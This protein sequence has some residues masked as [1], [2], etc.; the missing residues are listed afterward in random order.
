MKINTLLI[1]KKLSFLF[2]MFLLIAS[3]ETK[4]EV[5]SENVST[6]AETVEEDPLPSWNE[7]SSK[8]AIMAYVKDISDENSSNFIPVTDRIATF[9]NDGTLWSEQPIY[10]QFFF[11]LDRIKKMAENHPEWK[12]KQPYKAVLEN[13]MPTLMKQGKNGLVEIIMTTHAGMTTDEFE[14][15]VNDW[16]STAKHPEKDKLFTE[17]IY[18]PMLELLDYLRANNF[19]V[20]IVSGGGI[21]FMRPWTERVYSIPKENV[22]GSSVQTEYTWNDGKP[23]I[24][25]LAK[26]DLIDDKEGKPVGINR[27]IGKKPVF[28]AGNSDGDLQMLRW[29][30]A[31]S[32]KT[33]KL[34][35]HHTDAEREWAYDR[36]SHIGQFNIGLDEAEEKGWTLVNMKE[37]WKVIYPF[38]LN[39]ENDQ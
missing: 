2:L 36:D 16:I 9:D 15:L 10:F 22:V 37:D 38:Q 12:N 13:D 26:I 11:A 32:Y 1:A 39:E 33:F 28:A 7:G 4:K 30:D 3:C 8:E 14:T 17:L 6:P 20:F 34:Y 29:A 27:Y 35:V 21:E 18:Q 5:P 19:K 25:R 31:N 23:E 24:K